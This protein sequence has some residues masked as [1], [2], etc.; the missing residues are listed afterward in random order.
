MTICQEDHDQILADPNATTD[1]LRSIISE[2][3]A[4][5]APRIAKE[6]NGFTQHIPGF[7]SVETPPQRVP[8]KTTDDSALQER[9]KHERERVAQMIMNGSFLHTEA[10]VAIRA[11]EVAA[12]IRSMT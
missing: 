6:M 9:L 12:A 8:F 3:Q 5:L 11:R 1:E 10:P 7:V 2:L 4:E